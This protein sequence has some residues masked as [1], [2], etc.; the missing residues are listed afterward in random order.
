MRMCLLCRTRRTK[1]ELFRLTREAD[2]TFSF[3]PTQK[4]QGRGAYL[5]REKTC[6]EKAV[7]KKRISEALAAKLTEEIERLG[8][9]T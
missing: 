8:E 6:L 5:C 3:D 7:K 2:G 9:K 4:R 1:A